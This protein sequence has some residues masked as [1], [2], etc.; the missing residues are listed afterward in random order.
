[1]EEDFLEA[2]AKRNHYVN[3]KELYEVMKIYHEKYLEYVR[4][5]LIFHD[6]A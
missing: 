6:N 5:K 1:M 4:S 3:N 2:T